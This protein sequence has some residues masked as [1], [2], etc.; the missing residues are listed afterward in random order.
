[1]A[2]ED[3]YRAARHEPAFLAAHALDMRQLARAE[4]LSANG[5][6]RVRIALADGFD[7]EVLP[8]RGLDLGTASFAGTPLAFC[9]PALWQPGPTGAESFGRRFAAGLLTTG[10]LDHF[11]P[12]EVDAGQTL[13]QHG[14]A[15]ELVA[16]DLATGAEWTPDGYRVWVS[17]RMRQWRMF[18]ENLAWT[19]RISA[20]L[21]GN[22]LV[23]ED[24]VTN[25]GTESWPH[26]M[27]YHINFG[28]PLLDE[29]T[30]I[31]VAQP[32]SDRPGPMPVPRD[33]VAE[34]G[35]AQ[36]NVMPAPTAGAPEEVYRHDL[37]PAGPG[38][39]DVYNSR[40]ALT[41]AV[42]VDPRTLPWVW[43]WKMP[44]HGTYA[45]GIEP[46]NCPVMAGRRAARQQGVLMALDPG[47][48]RSYRVVIE[49]QRSPADA[50]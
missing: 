48:S 26:M 27:L 33:A 35:L 50:G 24:E 49:V 11:G 23:V 37:D 16:A 19:R 40:L 9:T 7:V 22:E 10:G 12:P 32:S 46:S 42:V 30:T 1:M 43:Q 34:R 39:V 38:R 21:G 41:A 6:R 36:W 13:P 5:S 20:V 17:G 29:G 44:G 14:A 28:Y 8:D 2:P 18:G 15:S 4:V 3:S 31:S 45:L 47:E 25:E